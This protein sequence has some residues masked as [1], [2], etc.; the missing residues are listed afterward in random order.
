MNTLIVLKWTTGLL[1]LCMYA[2]MDFTKERDKPFKVQLSKHAVGLALFLSFCY[3]DKIT[4]G[5]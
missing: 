5:L 2:I 3:L 1:F 4:G